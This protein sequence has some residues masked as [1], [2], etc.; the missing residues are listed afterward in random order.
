MK[1]IYFIFI[2]LFIVCFSS[3]IYNFD[4]VRDVFSQ[5][6]KI[7]KVGHFIG[8]FFLTWL[9]NST[10]KLP[11]INLTLTLVLYAALTEIGQY[12]LGF[13]KGEINDFI[14]DILGILTFMLIRW[15]SIMYIKNKQHETR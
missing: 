3:I 7:D 14:A 4:E 9:L 5:Y 2:L 11:L 12:Y 15:F 10:L 6:I 1:K 8:F 13:R